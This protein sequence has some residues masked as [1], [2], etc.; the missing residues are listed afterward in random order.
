MQTA[1]IRIRPATRQR[2]AQ[3]AAQTQSTVPKVLEAAVEAYRR[4]VFLEQ[5][6]RAF[7]QLHQDPKAWN[8]YRQEI[9]QWETTGNDGL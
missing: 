9:Q 2:L 6:N 8:E 7:A 4:Q 3:L 1:T 5:T